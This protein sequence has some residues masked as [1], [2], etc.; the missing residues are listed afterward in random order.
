M[1]SE[2]EGRVSTHLLGD[3]FSTLV[4][5]SRDEAICLLDPSGQIL[6]WNEG[7][8]Q[9]FGWH[10]H[11]VIGRP[12][13]VLKPEAQVFD[14]STGRELAIAAARGRF[15]S[16]TT[17]RHREGS[18]FRVWFSIVALRGGDGLAQAFGLRV[19]D[20]SDRRPNE[21]GVLHYRSLSEVIPQIVW[22]ASPDG[23]V[24]YFNR[25]WSELTGQTPEQSLGWGWQAA[26]HPDD[27]GPCVERWAEAVRSGEA[28]NIEYRLRRAF[29][30]SYRWYLGR[31]LR[32]S[33]DEGR[34][35][36]WFGTC[37]DIHD[38]KEA[39]ELLAR[40][41]RHAALRADVNAAFNQADISL[42]RV[43][44]RCVE[45]LIHH[46]DAAAVC[47]WRLDPGDDAPRLHA[48]AGLPTFEIDPSAHSPQ[49][50]LIAGRH[51][52]FLTNDLPGDTRAGLGEWARREGVVAFAG[53]PLMVEENPVGVLAVYDRRPM[54]IDVFEALA[55][56]ADAIAQG[57]HRKRL[58][59]ERAG[60]LAREQ[61]ARAE[62]EAASQAK[63]R[64]LSMLGHE[65]RTPLNPVLLAMTATLD[66]PTTPAE[67]RT[68]LEMS[69]RNLELEARLIDDLLDVTSG[70]RRPLQLS[71][72]VLDLHTLIGRT[73]AFCRGDLATAGIRLITDLAAGSCHVNADAA[74]MQQVVW[75]LVR[76]A[77]ESTS[78]GG[79]LT[80]RT[81]NAP[82]E[83]GATDRPDLIV[84]ISDTGVGIDPQALGRIFEAFERGDPGSSSRGAGLGLGLT[85]SRQVVEAHGGRLTAA[86]PGLGQGSTFSLTLPSVAAPVPSEVLSGT[87]P[88]TPSRPLRILL[89]EDDTSTLHVMTRLLGKPPYVVSTASSVAKAL[90]L[91]G[92]EDFDLIISDIGLPDGTGLDLMR[93]IRN[94]YAGRG[95]ALSGFGMEGD[96]M[97]CHEAGF[98]AHLTKPVNFRKLEAIIHDVVT[99]ARP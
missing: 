45:V 26:L 44:G 30:G 34:V 60:L 46:L 83:A 12:Y 59:E 4:G 36:K 28:Y 53:Y 91:A 29:D 97:K 69:R 64:L 49:I 48:C 57:I 81:R 27:R 21:A 80:I 67:I 89:V 19:R 38:Q 99:S 33:D 40:Q 22:T 31:G 73:L 87:I 76:N 88:P 24:D 35:V 98:A 39:E 43:L 92:T 8:E 10:S 95:I 85:I 63:D 58:E 14:G 68:T 72:E 18:H 84:E 9:V 93:Q 20:L 11:E 25:R 75:S 13:T 52:P 5:L 17:A 23:A 79:D 86:S 74:R 37:T 54:A 15:E 90:E 42:D 65:L 2:C 96:T 51:Q 32:L 3:L 55:S 1:T 50:A 16:E 47:L 77:K 71:R 7:A 70:R 78:S 56:V 82:A 41:A 94:R 6:S 66:D 61:Q 62:A